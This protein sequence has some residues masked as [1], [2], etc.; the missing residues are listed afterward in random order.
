[1][2]TILIAPDSFKG[3][4]SAQQVC[5]ITEKAFKDTVGE[6]NFIKLPLADGGEGLCECMHK[7]CGGEIKS[8]DVA[9][10]FGEPMKAE[11][12]ML[13]DSTAVIEMAAC[14]GL[15]L[16]GDNKNPCLATTKGVGE[17]MLNAVKQGAK[18]IMLGLG[19]SATNDCG[20]GMAYALGWRFYDK[21][22]NEI[23]PVGGNLQDIKSFSAPEEAFPI[24]VECAC[25]VKNPL[26]GKNG[27]AYVFS[28]QKGA[29][30]EMV[31]KLDEGLENM[32]EVILSETGK[33][34]AEIEGA[35]A[36]GGL[37]AG[38]VVFAGAV[39]RKGIEIILDTSGFDSLLPEADLVITGEG[40]LDSQSAQGKVIS[41]VAKRAS[42]KGK[43]VV[44]LCGCKGDGAEEILNHGVSKMYFCCNEPKPFEQVVKDCETDLYN[45]TKLIAEDFK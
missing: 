14:A 10:V 37:G 8:A 23:F 40:R 3:T 1:M 35:G 21:N 41:G 39:L 43:T 17:L 29:D 25:D 27:A 38:A 11:Y 33:N 20:T 22:K 44:T 15:P 26:Y 30:E 13:S 34:V 18:K 2:K 16:A 6:C 42:A 19:G 5:D 12:L 24:P 45:A 9:G 28:P 4:L 36:A 7:I 31:K 32:A